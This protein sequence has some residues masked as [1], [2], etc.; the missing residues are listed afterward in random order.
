MRFITPAILTFLIGV[1][2]WQ[3]LDIQS[4]Q[5][6][7]VTEKTLSIGEKETF[8]QDIDIIQTPQDEKWL[9]QMMDSAQKNIQVAVYIFTVPSLR[10]ALIRAQNRGVNVR[11][12]LE[13]SPYNL[14]GINKE[15][16]KVF[17]DNK[18]AFYESDER[19]FSFMHAKYM[20]FDEEWIISTAN[21]TRSSF[22][23]NREF[24]LIGGDVRVLN[25]LKTVFETD[26][27]GRKWSFDTSILLIG[28]THARE[29]LIQFAQSS[30]KFLSLYTPSIT[31][32]EVI[33]ELRKI[34]NS[35]REI[36]IIIDENEENIKSRI[37]W[38][39]PKCPEIRMMKKPILH[40]KSL[41][42]DNEQAFVW[43]FNFTQNSLEKNRELGIFIEGASISTIVNSFQKDWDKSIAF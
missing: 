17:T 35:G 38:V 36:Y 6:Y 8:L 25:E 34:C 20:I 15:T 26:F 18:I 24:F 29:R 7:H 33:S 32:T 13:K 2:V 16:K 4:Y 31:D 40:A 22:S 12:I 42:R 10:D 3:S 11:V 9:L 5:E 39:Q 43:S 37:P 27:N 23:S 1:L 41:I 28:P 30:Q 14:T 19:Y 21:W